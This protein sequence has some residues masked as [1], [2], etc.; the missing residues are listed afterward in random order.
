MMTQC[1]NSAVR[2][3]LWEGGKS[4]SESPE[5]KRE[6]ERERERERD[7]KYGRR[8]AGRGHAECRVQSAPASSSSVQNRW[9][10][11]AVQLEQLLLAEKEKRNENK[12]DLI[13][14]QLEA[15]PNLLMSVCFHSGN[16]VGPGYSK[17]VVYCVKLHQKRP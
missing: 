14:A 1:K 13:R 17:E 6:R 12:V 8:E 11:V 16:D 10:D 4:A 7:D 3:M 15:V 9:T 2:D 5:I